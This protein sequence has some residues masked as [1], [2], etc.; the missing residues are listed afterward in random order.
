MHDTPAE[1][2][3]QLKKD[4]NSLQMDEFHNGSLK[5]I[6]VGVASGGGSKIC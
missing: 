6:T 4:E 5:D 3:V 1:T 2:I